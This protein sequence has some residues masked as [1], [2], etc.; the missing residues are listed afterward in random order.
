M[1]TQRK[2]KLRLEVKGEG[3]GVL[4]LFGVGLEDFLEG[5]FSLLPQLESVDVLKVLFDGDVRW[6]SGA[7]DASLI[8]RASRVAREWESLELVT[9]AVVDGVVS[10]AALE[11]VALCDLVYTTKESR[12]LVSKDFVPLFGGIQRVAVSCGLSVAK[13]LFF[14]GECPADEL[15]GFVNKS[16]EGR[17]ELFSFVEEEL[18][19]ILSRS[20]VAVSM[21]KRIIDSTLLSCLGAGLAL[22]R[23]MFGFAFITEDRKE[24]MRAFFEKRKPNFRRREC[25]EL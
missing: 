4:P 12:F 22:E 9:V 16:F 23:E 15:A 13:R 14:I 19:M 24:G 3:L 11:L 7:P 1:T 6:S 21:T 17:V 18:G 10:D 2:S 5:F 20:K 25:H 8:K